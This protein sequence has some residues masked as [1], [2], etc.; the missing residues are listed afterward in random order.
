[1][2]LGIKPYNTY[3]NTSLEMDLDLPIDYKI[4][5]LSGN[6]FKYVFSPIQFELLFSDKP[7]VELSLVSQYDANQKILIAA[8]FLLEYGCYDW[9]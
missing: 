1:M 5:D 7:A 2:K 9:R 4:F 6:P 3:L 8:L